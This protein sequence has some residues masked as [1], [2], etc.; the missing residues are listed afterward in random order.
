MS[1]RFRTSLETTSEP[2]LRRLGALPRAVPVLAVLALIAA[3]ALLPWGW[4]C[5]VLV[6][7]FLAWLLVLGWPH[8]SAAERLLR[9]AVLVLLLAVA[10]VQAVPRPA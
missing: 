6:L 8:L 2:L 10:V 9:I 5:T 4:V 1:S 7:L 3:G